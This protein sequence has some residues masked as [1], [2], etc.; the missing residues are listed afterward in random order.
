LAFTGR[1]ALKLSDGVNSGAVEGISLEDSQHTFK[2][3]NKL[4][5]LA[6]KFPKVTIKVGSG[7]NGEGRSHT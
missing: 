3:T 4:A 1:N 5:T 7:V 6:S 2:R